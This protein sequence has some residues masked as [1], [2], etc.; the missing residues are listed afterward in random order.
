MK[1]W[2]IL[3][4]G[5]FICAVQAAVSSNGTAEAKLAQIRKLLK[6]QLSENA[7]IV[8]PNSKEWVEV[9]H[10]AA[11]PRVHPGY[12]AVVDVAVEDDVVNTVSGELAKTKSTNL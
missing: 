9:T 7:T 3:G 11:A 6:P 5:F 1:F 10:R 2:S 4:A 12:L 8:F